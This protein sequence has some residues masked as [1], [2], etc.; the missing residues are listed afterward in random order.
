V[1]TD[2]LAAGDHPGLRIEVGSIAALLADAIDRLH[3]HRDIAD[4]LTTG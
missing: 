4:L 3:G 1:V 2:S